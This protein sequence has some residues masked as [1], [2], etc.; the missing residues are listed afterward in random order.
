[1]FDDSQ[2]INRFMPFDGDTPIV[3]LK[4]GDVFFNPE[5]HRLATL[6]GSCVAVCL[7]DER[8]RMGGM[9]HSIVPSRT[10]RSRTD[11]LLH[12]TDASIHELVQ[13]MLAAGCHTNA[14]QAKLFGGFAPLK[15][16]GKVNIGAANIRSAIQ[17]LESYHIA[18]VAREILGQ[19]GIVIY[20]DT[21]TGDV[22]GR[23]IAPMSLA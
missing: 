23:R 14:M 11:D 16:L 7:W 6:L 18:I 1:M 17:V 12:A 3:R 21:A 20:Q 15:V 5:P 22:S 19:G 9:T 13:R 10:G 2:K 4:P 8:R